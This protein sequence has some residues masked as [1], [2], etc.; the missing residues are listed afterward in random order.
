MVLKVDTSSFY[1]FFHDVLLNSLQIQNGSPFSMELMSE[2]CPL[3]TVSCVPELTPVL[4][5]TPEPPACFERAHLPCTA[6]GE[7]SL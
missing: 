6:Q 4:Y 5:L 7:P 2:V 3:R 1:C